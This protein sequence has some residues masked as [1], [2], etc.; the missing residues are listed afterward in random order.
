MNEKQLNRKLTKIWNGSF[1]IPNKILVPKN[2]LKES[3]MKM[4]SYKSNT[5]RKKYQRNTF[6]IADGDIIK[7]SSLISLIDKCIEIKRGRL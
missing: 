7:L 5:W 1:G 3:L 2:M 4:N 6:G